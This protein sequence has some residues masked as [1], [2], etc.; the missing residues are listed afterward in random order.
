MHFSLFELSTRKNIQDILYNE[1][2]KNLN[3]T[4]EINEA[5]LEKMI[6]LKA[7]V[8]EVFR[9]HPVVVILGRETIQ[10]MVLN[11]YRVPKGV[12]FIFI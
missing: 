12:R 3:D 4:N 7:F 1:I 5:V 2:E 6:Y 11:G 10:D 9:F 8:K